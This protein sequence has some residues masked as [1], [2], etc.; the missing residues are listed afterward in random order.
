MEKRKFKR[1]LVANRG[2]I[3]I[4]I[5]RACRELGIR[6]VAI[7]SEEDSLS[8]FRTKADESYQ[9]GKGKNPVDAY[10]DIDEIIHLAKNKGVDAIHPGYG[11]LA[12][13]PDFAQK[14]EE[15][16]IVFI[17]PRPETM[18]KLGDKISSKIIAREAG[19]K[20]IPGVEEPIHSDTEAL[21]FAKQAAYPV[22]IKAAAG[23]GGR[24]MRVV[25]SEEELLDQF[26]SAKSEAKKAFGN[27]SMFIEKYLDRPKH[28]EVQVL[29]DLYGNVVHLHERDCSIQRRHQKVIEFTP[30][31]AVDEKIREAIC[32]DALKITKNLGYRSAGTVEFLVDSSGNHYFIEVNPRI[33]VEHTVTEMVTGIDIIQAQIQI[34]QGYAL[35]DEPINIPSQ[36]AIVPRGFSIQCRV[37]TEDP[38]NNFAP[39]TGQ[40]TL[41]RS[42]SGFGVRLDGGNGF[43]GAVIS[44]YYDSLLVKVITQGRTWDDTVNKAIRSLREI[45]V[46]GVKTNIGFLLNVLNTEE[47][48]KG[49]C[50]TGFIAEHQELFDINTSTDR[51]LRVMEH[52]GNIV[53]NDNTSRK[54]AFDVPVVP[55]YKEES[56]RGSKQIFDE[57]GADKLSQWI[58]DQDRL[59]LTDTTMRDAHQSL[60]ATRMRTVD[61]LKVAKSMNYNIRDIFSMEMWGGATFD[62]AYRF[63]HEDP[64]HRLDVLREAMPNLLMQ[65]LVRGN[66]TVGYKNYPDNVVKKFIKESAEGGI[67]IFRIFDSLN[68]IEGMRLAIEETIANGK[69]AEGTMCYTGDILD[70]KRDKYSLEYY[71]NLAKDLEKAGCHIIGIKDMSGLLK[72]YA[73]HKL[74]KALKNEVSIPIHLHTHDTTGNGV[75]TVLMAAEAG[76]D[77]ADTAINSMSG[78]TSQP[79]LN[80]VVAALENTS[81]ST[82]I[83]LDAIDRISAYW[84]AVRPVYENFESD[85]K[86]GTTEIYK[87]EIPGGQYSNL[88]P[89]VESFGLGHKFKE[90]KEMYKDVNQMVGDI[91]KVTP[92]SKMVG[93][94]SIFMVQND[95]TPENIYE[96]GANLDYPDS[97]VTYFKGMMGQPYG[98]F[99]EKLQKIVLKDEKPISVRP[100]KLLDPEDYEADKKYLRSIMEHEPS[101]RDVTSYSLYPKVF[102]EYV[103]NFSKYDQLWRMGSDVFF[104]GLQEGETAEISV[105]EGQKM[106]VTLVEVGRL[107]DDGKRTVTFEINGSRRSVDIEDHTRPLPITGHQ[108]SLMADENNPDQVGASIPGTVAKINVAVGDKVKESQ[109]LMVLEAMKME[110]NVISPRSGVIAQIFAKEG[111]SIESGQLLI[112]L[113]S[114]D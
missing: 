82:G 72:P 88:K 68:W 12:E 19:V 44:P 102:E 90:V 37:T 104:H 55:P 61:L 57:L 2:E 23:G 50:D 30:A 58:L 100:G 24:G 74:I 99:P 77:I 32:N 16:G 21:E 11:F 54:K 8:L 106:I 70:E 62:V 27:D 33:Q 71:V 67:D 20:T 25:Y 34:A 46:G 28:I 78:L 48:K 113:E 76:V 22:M 45:K 59:L 93:D 3:A 73:A 5:F 43:Q 101:E 31:F 39:D 64:W 13:N 85:L 96:K 17:G 75:A 98:G 7:Y 89:Q 105:N 38:L 114:E 56:F 35:S 83:D 15:A 112:E 40:I 1:I 109:P 29:G 53:V 42:S 60:M 6:S 80:S 86:S 103:K 66:N 18:R 108:G 97:V 111:D 41:Y 47:F 63:L 9:I 65:M 81:R 110:T 84:A 107:K 87:Y 26:H 94:M 95:L 91:I 14:C 79:A 92:S 49:I 51:E 4:R 69:I 10:L 52:I 36:E